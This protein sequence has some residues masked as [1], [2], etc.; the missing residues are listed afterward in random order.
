MGIKN[1][2]N[3]II[4]EFPNISSKTKPKNIEVLCIDV[5]TILH[6]VCHIA[7]SK[8]KYGKILISFLKKEINLIKPKFVAIFTDGQAILAKANTQIKR[9]NKY[10]YNKSSGISS[11]NL[12]PGT[13]FMDYI[14][15]TII[16]YLSKLSIKSYYSSSKENNEGE[17]KLFNW[18]IKENINGNICVYGNDS[19][20]IV[21][22]LASRPLI[23]IYIY[24]DVNFIS[25]KELILCLSKFTPNK[26]NFKWHPVRMDFVLLSLF[27]GNDYNS[28]ISNFK[29]LVKGYKKLQKKKEGFLIRRNGEL[30]LQSI[31]KLLDYIKYKQPVI[32]DYANVNSYFKCIQ[33]N[34]NLYTNK[35]VSNFIPSYDVINITSILNNFP[36]KITFNVNELKW[37]HPDVYLLM[38]MPVTGK[39]LLPNRLKH[40]M[41]KDSPIK[42][43]F[44]EPCQICIEWKN[45]LKSFKKPPEEEK[46]EMSN[47]KRLI[48]ETNVSYNKHINEFHSNE[49]LPI[50]RIQL[51]VDKL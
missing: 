21:L 8:E 31:R 11:L 13:P 5:N 16:E 26:F 41:D 6:K 38:L 17:I 44:P 1:Y 30:N 9:R 28:S 42:D 4:K 35:M 12:T 51:E 39:D 24:N 36:K 47:Y 25:I 45:K 43:L 19:D 48:S 23:D 14:D 34:I 15:D 33:W 37:L 32:C 40:L 22:S 18:L 29:N 10:L 49:E 50:Q 7:K 2:K 3:N 20:I 46:E 27:Q